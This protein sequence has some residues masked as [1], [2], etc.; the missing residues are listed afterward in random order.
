LW[1]ILLVV[2]R[3]IFEFSFFLFTVNLVL[4]SVRGIYK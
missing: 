4:V 3:S 2:M 1:D